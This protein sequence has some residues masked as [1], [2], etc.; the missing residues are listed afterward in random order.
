[1]AKNHSSIFSG[2]LKTFWHWQAL[3]AD[4]SIPSIRKYPLS[5]SWK[6]L[7][8]AED[9]RSWGPVLVFNLG[10]VGGK[11]RNLFENCR[12]FEFARV[13]RAKIRFACTFFEILSALFYF[14]LVL[15][16]NSRYLVIND[17]KI[18]DCGNFFIFPGF[19]VKLRTFF[20]LRIRNGRN[21]RDFCAKCPQLWELS[22]IFWVNLACPSLDLE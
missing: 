1:M 9:S 14:S 16:F 18:W 8:F 13:F 15:P 7:E 4:F 17:S 3:S 5:A 12:F 2:N 19:F 6:I 11:K 21:Y 10:T 22:S 20:N